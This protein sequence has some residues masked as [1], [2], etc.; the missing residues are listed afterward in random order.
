MI[1]MEGGDAALKLT[2]ASYYR[3]SGVN[4]HRFPDSSREDKWG[5]SPSDGFDISL[6]PEQWDA[7]YNDRRQRDVIP[8]E[9]DEPPS[10]TFEDPQLGKAVAWLTDQLDG[11][12]PADTE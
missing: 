10:R 12:K 8:R 1:R 9:G 11:E 3:P 7:W 2:T 4:I 5:V 6:S